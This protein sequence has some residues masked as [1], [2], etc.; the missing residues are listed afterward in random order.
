MAGEVAEANPT[1]GQSLDSIN[2][3][4]HGDGRLIRLRTDDA[5]ANGLLSADEYAEYI[6]EDST[7]HG[8]HWARER[9]GEG[10]LSVDGASAGGAPAPVVAVTPSGKREP[11]PPSWTTSIG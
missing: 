11:A 10:L 8:D 1:L 6:A 4:S 3:D 5:M 9:V 7:V 2:D